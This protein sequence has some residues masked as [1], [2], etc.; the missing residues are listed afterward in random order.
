MLNLTDF[1]NQSQD[2]SG[3]ERLDYELIQRNQTYLTLYEK[4]K[5]NDLIPVIEGL[6]ALLEKNHQPKR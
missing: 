3:L 5:A 6:E 4:I 1:S 2:E